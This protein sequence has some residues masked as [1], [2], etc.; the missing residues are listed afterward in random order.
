VLLT[1]TPAA[2]ALLRRR[3]PV[4]ILRE[5]GVNGQAEM[6]YAFHA[7]GFDAIDVHMSDLLEG[8]QSL[9]SFVG[10][11]ACGGFSYGDV[12]GAGRGWAAAIR[13]HP[14]VRAAFA[15]FLARP[16]VFALGVCNGCQMFAALGDSVPGSEHW[17]RFVRNRS[18][19]FEARWAQ[20]EIVESRSIFFSNLGGWRLP[21]AVA[22]G[23][24]RALFEDPEDL[25]RLAASNQLPLRYIDH[26]GA[27]AERYPAN[28]NGSPGGITAVCNNDGR[29][30]ILMPHPERTIAGTTG[31]WW[32]KGERA[33]TPWLEIFHNAR[34]WVG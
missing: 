32:P 14:Q 26:R 19:Q 22:H 15:A 34:R 4:A 1:S 9:A 27:P 33:H 8:R 12:L 16:D 10:L 7:A 23:E 28:P 6:A 18:E 11:A 17:P 13:F 29:I 3:P 31:S 20:V 30:T 2:P 25:Q 21:T 24:G 5:Q